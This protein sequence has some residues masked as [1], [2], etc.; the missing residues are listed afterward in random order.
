VEFSGDARVTV[1][2]LELVTPDVC[3]TSVTPVLF[4]V[5]ASVSST[6]DD[7]VLLPVCEYDPVFGVRLLVVHASVVDSTALL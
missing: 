2:T 3:T 1:I 7:D 6:S 4:L 5:V